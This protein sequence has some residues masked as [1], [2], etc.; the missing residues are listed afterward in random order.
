MR[1]ELALTFAAALLLGASPAK[2]PADAVYRGGKIYTVDAQRSWAQA[3]AIR[4][5]RF[6]AVGS[7]EEIAPWV[8]PK[9]RVVELQGR[10]VL[11]GI[12]DLHEHLVEG[13]FQKLSE[14]S[15]PFPT[16]GR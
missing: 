10:M 11:P 4:E 15:F 14:C 1:A 6:V 13:G 9:T 2:P 3:V 5:G 12:H 7:D 16:D 8:G